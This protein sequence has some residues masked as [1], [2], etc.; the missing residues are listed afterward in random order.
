MA[1]KNGGYLGRD[2]IL[3]AVDLKYEDVACPEWGD[4]PVHVRELTAL[5]RNQ[6]GA[7]FAGEGAGNVPP[8]FYPKLASW[9]IV[10]ANGV[11]LF[12]EDDLAGL[13]GKKWEPIQRCV[14]VALRLSGMTEEAAEDLGKESEPTLSDASPSA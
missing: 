1:Q 2:A 13:G 11:A 14:D 7:Q 4:L 6:L 8:D 10:D 5:E 3:R 12:A 9:V